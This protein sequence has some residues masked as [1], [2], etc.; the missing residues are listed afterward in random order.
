VREEVLAGKGADAKA[1]ER[2]IVEHRIEVLAV[3]HKGTV[4]KLME[5]FN[6]EQGEA[7]TIA[8]AAGKKDI[9]VATDDRNAI[10]ACKILKLDFITAVSILVRAS[11]K[12]LLDNESALLK[13]DKLASVGRYTVEIM[14][15]AK[16]CMGGR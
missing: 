16:K 14:E 10:K 4:R 8:L 3:A 6:I 5:D 1:I 13:L 7:E 15:H 2:I 11:E 12:G 9:S